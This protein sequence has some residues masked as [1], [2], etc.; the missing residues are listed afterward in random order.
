[1]GWPWIGWRRWPSH[2]SVQRLAVA[3]SVYGSSG[4]CCEAE[5]VCP[6]VSLPGFYIEDEGVAVKNNIFLT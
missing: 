1:M 6:S 2:L 3:P 4:F 5:C